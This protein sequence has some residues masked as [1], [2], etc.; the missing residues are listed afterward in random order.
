MSR[1]KV[2][3]LLVDNVNTVE[4]DVKN[5]LREMGYELDAI[6]LSVNEV[7]ESIDQSPPDL[8][9]MD[10]HLEEQKKGIKTAKEIQ[11]QFD[12]PVIFLS[13]E[14]NYDMLREAAAADVYGFVS[15]PFDQADLFG[16]IELALYKHHKEQQIFRG[17]AKNAGRSGEKKVKKEFIFVRADYK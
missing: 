4:I 8:V 10:I 3:I 7:F 16:S 13:G 17:G 1:E 9:L 2:K 11:E 12:I 14:T 15:K 6:A 5:R